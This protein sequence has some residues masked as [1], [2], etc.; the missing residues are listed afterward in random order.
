M[1]KLAISTALSAIAAPSEE[2]AE[3]IGLC[4]V[5]V[6]AIDARLVSGWAEQNGSGQQLAKLRERAEGNLAGEV[7]RAVGLS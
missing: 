1:V 5:A 2:S 7:L 3:I 6:S 4:G